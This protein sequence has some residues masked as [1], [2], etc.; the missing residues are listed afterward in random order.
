MNAITRTEAEAMASD[1]QIG[2]LRIPPHSVEAE[3]SLL[4]GLLLDNSAW[5]RV[6]DLLVDDDFYVYQHK[7][8]YAAIGKLV[9]A[10]KMADVVTVWSALEQIG[11]GDEIGGLAYLNA[12]AQ[13]V[14]SAANGRRYAEI[15]R[16]RSIFRQLVSASDEIATTA[17]NPGEK[18]AVDLIDAAQSLIFSLGDKGAPRDDWQDSAEG[19]TRVLDGIQ[20][21]HDGDD[22]FTPTGITAL[23]DKLNGGM[24]AGN[25]IVIAARPSMG[26]TALA[27]SIADHVGANEGKPVGVMS[28][29]MPKDEVQNRRVSMRSHVPFHKIMRPERMSDYDWSQMSAGVEALMQVPVYVSDQTALTINQVRTKARKL[30]RSKGLAVL[31]VDYIGLMEGTDRKAN[32]ATQLGEVSRGM[33]ALAKELGICILLLAQLNREV[34]KRPGQRPIM[35]DLRECGDIEQDADIIVFVHRP[36]QFNR[37]LGPD[38][39][40]YAELIVGKNRSG[41]CGM[42]DA[43]F[44]GESMRFCNWAGDRPTSLVRTKGGD[45]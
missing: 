44:V 37:E 6:S 21:R 30:K 36:Y 11:K 10:N 12:L 25:V 20:A 35:A 9:N 18:T 16:E 38:W 34:E 23:D 29:E 43:Q 7:L 22:D 40:Y 3:S 1:S 15:V 39:K 32:R 8:I 19:V 13:Y 5:D 41:E 45:L 28:M 24:R 4:G 14:P 27:L 42:V 17:F 26:K 33:K 2:A 31:V